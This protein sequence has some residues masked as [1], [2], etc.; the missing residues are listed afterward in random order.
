MNNEYRVDSY[1]SSY[2]SEISDKHVIHKQK[3]RIYFCQYILLFTT[4]RLEPRLE[5]HCRLLRDFWIRFAPPKYSR[6]RHP[7]C[8]DCRRRRTTGGTT[9]STGKFNQEPHYL[10]WIELSRQIKGVHFLPFEQKMCYK[11]TRSFRVFLQIFILQWKT[12][13]A[14][15][16]I[17]M[18]W[19]KF[20]IAW[21]IAT[22]S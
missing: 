5:Q 4:C 2:L 20:W 12:N 16:Y 6:G 22:A 10:K 9:A 15:H 3:F 18:N 13:P 19:R 14:I 7:S 11:R 8:P 17:T 1:H 21:N